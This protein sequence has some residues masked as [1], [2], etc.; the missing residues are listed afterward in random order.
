MDYDRQH[1]GLLTFIEHWWL[2]TGAVV[3]LLAVQA[4]TFFTQLKGIPWIW[5]CNVSFGLMLVG[6]A[7]I[8]YAKFPVYR[9]GRFFT[10]G[11]KS[12]PPH[13]QN[14]YLWGWRMFLVGVALSLCLMLSKP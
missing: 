6:A 12:V 1:N 8:A 10:L 11:L 7:L 14:F 4:F 5:F 9:S 13:L 2:A 3:I